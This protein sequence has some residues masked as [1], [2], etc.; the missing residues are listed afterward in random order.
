MLRSCS[1]L[2]AAT[3]ARAWPMPMPAGVEGTRGG[4]EEVQGADDLLAQPHRQG[5]HGREPGV[6]GGGGEPGPAVCLGGEIGD[7]D[8]PAGPEAVQAGSLVVLQLEQ[9]Q[10]PGRLA[11]RGDDAQLAA[12]VGQQQPGGGDVQQLDAAAGQHMHKVDHVE[13]GDHGVGQLDERP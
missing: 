13:P 10:Q 12:R 2:M 6:A 3:S 7:G 1:R 9:F 5:L 11:G 4:A 8:G